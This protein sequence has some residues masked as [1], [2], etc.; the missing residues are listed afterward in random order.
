L[1][2][3][4]EIE[5]SIMFRGKD[6]RSGFDAIDNFVLFTIKMIKKSGFK[7]LSEISKK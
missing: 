7:Y 4:Q 3:W 2:E 6:Y 5:R 1:K